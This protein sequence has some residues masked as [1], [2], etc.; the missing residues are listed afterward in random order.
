MAARLPRPRR[1]SSLRL[2]VLSGLAA[3]LVLGLGTTAAAGAF[4]FDEYLRSRAERTLAANSERV[5]ALVATGPQTV[6]GDQLAAVIGPPLGIVA[7]DAD[8]TALD[9]AGTTASAAALIG[10]GVRAAPPG[11]TVRLRV[12]GHE[13]LA[14]GLPSPGLTVRSSDEPDAHPTTLVLVIDASVDDATIRSLILRQAGIVTLALVCLLGLAVV[15]LN[16]GLRPLARMVR[17]ADAIAA[18]RRSERMPLAGRHSEI[19]DLARAVN[20]A[21]DAQARAEERVRSFAADASHELRTPLATIS[22]WLD[23]YRQGALSAEQLEAAVAHIDD[24]AGRM[25]LL[26]D[27]LALLAR[28]DAGRPIG[29]D[30]LD[31]AALVQD[32]LADARVIDPHRGFGYEGPAGVWIK[33]D[34]ARLAQVLRNLVGNA[35]QH[36]PDGTA[37]RVALSERPDGVRIAVSDD[38]PGIPAAHLEHVFERFWRGDPSHSRATGGSGLGLAIVRAI[39][40]AHGGRVGVTSVAGSGATGPTGTTVTVEL[41][42]AA[43]RPG[44]GPSS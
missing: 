34:A 35:A 3:L 9:H 12:E 38:G 30:A 2:R 27:E 16:V 44:P 4:V 17:S 15:V 24:A 33:G 41:P 39:V 20:D 8:G 23:L 26:V 36:T 1:P 22:G 18:G 31:V 7:L 32:V 19:D 14:R 11:E 21:L 40:T 43:R 25:R 42:R 6:N 28:F 37:V 5:R 10:A 13:L 29:R